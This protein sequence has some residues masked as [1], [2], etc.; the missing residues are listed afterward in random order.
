MMNGVFKLVLVLLIHLAV[1]ALAQV[2]GEN[3]T[4]THYPSS[5]D[6]KGEPVLVQ[7]WFRQGDDDLSCGT[8]VP[9]GLAS[10]NTPLSYLAFW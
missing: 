6:C 8:N 5:S 9:S 2:R 10:S 3:F 4:I 7:H 1:L